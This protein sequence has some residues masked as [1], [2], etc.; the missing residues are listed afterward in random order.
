MFLCARNH[1][2]SFSWAEHQIAATLRTCP[3]AILRN[4]LQQPPPIRHLAAQFET[5][6]RYR[7]IFSRCYR[8]GL[9]L[10]DNFSIC[11]HRGLSLGD[12]MSLGGIR[13]D[14]KRNPEISQT[15]ARLP[16]FLRIEPTF[17]SFRG[18]AQVSLRHTLAKQVSRLESHAAV[19]GL[20]CG[21]WPSWEGRVPILKQLENNRKGWRVGPGQSAGETSET[22]RK[23][24]KH[25]KKTVSCFSGCVS[26]FQ[27][28]LARDPLGTFFSCF[29]GF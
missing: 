27:A 12:G 4:A 21:H 28:T 22:A 8:R 7:A 16:Q 18:V 10:G 13:G 29:P 20:T 11:Y 1:D 9:S 23:Q 14:F 15:L 25:Q 3:Q 17:F 6:P 19:G 5:P 2:V 26:V 24:T